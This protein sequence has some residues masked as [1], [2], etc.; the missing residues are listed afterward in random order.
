MMG[1]ATNSLFMLIL[2]AVCGCSQSTATGPA[3]YNSCNGNSKYFF[4]TNGTWLSTTSS[5]YSIVDPS[6]PLSHSQGNDLYGGDTA[7]IVDTNLYVENNGS[8]SFRTIGTQ[9]YP[10]YEALSAYPRHLAF[11][12][13]YLYFL[14]H[15][16]YLGGSQFCWQASD[17][18][19]ELD[20]DQF[21]DTSY[22]A[23]LLA[24]VPLTDPDD[25][26]IDNS[27]LFVLDGVSGLKIFN[28]SSPS[29]PSLM[30]TAPNIQGYHMQLTDQSTLLVT[31]DSGLMQY[32]ISNPSNP[33]FVSKIQ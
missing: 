13:G 32:D 12:P 6:N 1:K 3:Q 4:T 27:S 22:A 31:S 29:H 33:A 15:T 11:A 17:S 8:I 7:F 28:V 18:V 14:R 16:T 25:I 9:T 20:V 10:Q 23:T 24:R 21:S 2:A 26:A 30:A 19:N 5:L